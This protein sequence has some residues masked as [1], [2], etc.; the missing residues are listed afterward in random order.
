MERVV[1]G[2]RNR[3]GWTLTRKQEIKND[4]KTKP[5]HLKTY[6]TLSSVM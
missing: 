5:K 3:W 2:E 4:I 1:C 6:P